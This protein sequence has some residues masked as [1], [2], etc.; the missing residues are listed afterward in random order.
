[1][2]YR[3]GTVSVTVVHAT[4]CHYCD[5]AEQALASYA[6][7]FLLDVR[8][9]DIDSHEGRRLIAEHRP[10]MNPLVL[11]NGAFFS[12]G[13]LPRRKLEKLLASRYASVSSA[14]EGR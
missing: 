7:R 2:V 11:V 8:T 3:A 13:R 1:M 14:A 10:A 5:D 6:G 4:A 12:S 9:V